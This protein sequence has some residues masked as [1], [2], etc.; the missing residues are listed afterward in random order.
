M[1]SSRAAFDL[2][3]QAGQPCSFVRA[4]NL[5]HSSATSCFF[6]AVAFSLI[7]STIRPYGTSSIDPASFFN[8]SPSSFCDTKQFRQVLAKADRDQC[9]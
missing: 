4:R 2:F 5:T 1:A 3:G 8:A 9:T 6:A 7:C